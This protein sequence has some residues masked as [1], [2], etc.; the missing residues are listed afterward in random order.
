[1]V[2]AEENS[3]EL[4]TSGLQGGSFLLTVQRGLSFTA[5]YGGEADVPPRYGV[6]DVLRA[7]TVGGALN[8]G[9][10][11]EIGTIEVGKK[12]DL[13]VIALDQVTTRLFG[14]D[15]GAVVDCG[16]PAVVDT[17]IIDG[18][19]KK[20]GGELVGVDYEA[21]ARSGEASR[22]YLLDRY[23]VTEEDIRAGLR[24]AAES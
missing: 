21:L 19:I 15:I 17:V 18:K 22:S 14:S 12:A 3:C 13:V 5:E 7:A 8:A 9:R 6:E 16:S 24:V 11:A 1:M 10:Q 2:V 4:L 20:W 23:G